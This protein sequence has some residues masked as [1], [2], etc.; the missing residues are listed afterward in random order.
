MT[1]AI[2]KMDYYV[3]DGEKK[4]GRYYTLYTADKNKDVIYTSPMGNWKWH[5]LEYAKE[6]NI[7]ILE[8]NYISTKIESL[9]SIEKRQKKAIIDFYKSLHILSVEFHYNTISE[10]NLNY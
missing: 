3:K 5:I 9:E 6:N 7:E 2:L 8:E 1:K 4:I 10:E